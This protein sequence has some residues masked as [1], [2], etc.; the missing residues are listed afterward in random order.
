MRRML[1]IVCLLCGLLACN[2]EAAVTTTIDG[3]A[4]GTTYHIVVRSDRTLEIQNELD[5]LFASANRS[6]SL[7]DDS[8][9]L[10]RINRNETDSLDAHLIRCIEIAK[11][12]SRESDGLYDITVKPLSEVWGFA[13]RDKTSNPNIDSLLRFVGYEKISI[14]NGRL[15]KQNPGTQFDLN[16]IAKGYI[17]DL[18]AQYLDSLGI[19]NYLVEIGGEI[20]CKGLNPKNKEWSVAIDRPVEGNFTPGEDVQVILE[21]TN[22][23]LA[24]SGN[25][26]RFYT[27]ESGRKIVHTIN[28]KT[29]MSQISNLL[30]A[31]ILA[32]NCAL[33]DAYGTMMMAVGLDKA[34]EILE[35]RSDIEG[36]LVYTDE[37]GNYQT[38]VSSGLKDNIK[39]P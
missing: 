23:G 15:V 29:G 39:K 19:A 8:S 32:E 3:F 24:T 37:K 30:S 33:A 27:D 17:V 12:V 28:P 11:G 26:R 10:C 9:L 4:L 35:S 21:I 1:I 2:R 34:M 31:T 22:T 25:Y 16:S 6:M 36:F 18:V 20:D 14:V 38:F 13:A 5:S 7:Y